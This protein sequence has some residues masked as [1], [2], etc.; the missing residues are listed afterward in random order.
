MKNNNYLNDLNYGD[1]LAE[2]F[3]GVKD[4]FV[5]VLK[6]NILFAF[7]FAGLVFAFSKFMPQ[8]AMSNPGS[9]K[10]SMI[11]FF[12]LYFWL[13]FLFYTATA[14]TVAS[15]IENKDL[16]TFESLN[17]SALPSINFMISSLL[18]S[19]PISAITLTLYLLKIDIG[20]YK[21][22]IQLVLLVPLSFFIFTLFAA[23]LRDKGP[24]ASMGYSFFLIKGN[25]WKTYLYLL[26]PA[27]LCVGLYALFTVGVWFFI[28]AQIFKFMM[29]MQQNIAMFIVWVV[30]IAIVSI[31][32]NIFITTFMCR[33]LGLLFMH[34]ERKV[35]KS[36]PEEVA[37]LGGEPVVKEQTLSPDLPAEK[38]FESDPDSTE[39]QKFYKSLFNDV[40]VDKSRPA[41][42]M[43]TIVVDL[44]STERRNIDEK[45][46]KESFKKESGY[47]NPEITLESTITASVDKEFEFTVEHT[48]FL[49]DK[50]SEST[51]VQ[52]EPENEP[53]PPAV[54]MQKLKVPAKPPVPPA[55]K[56]EDDT[57]D[58]R[59]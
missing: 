29:M 26:V 8:M 34:L 5:P 21:Y 25:W 58:P 40:K 41:N 47:H 33:A 50:P 13:I 31:A 19:V 12:I 32:L 51:S 43:P 27:L 52:K 11:A 54:P 30:V 20:N 44:D 35:L 53:L 46:L 2:C 57:N 42:E 56:K 55:Q 10:A 37:D 18:M 14:N 49:P 38:V 9:I 3:A 16:G 59:M 22:L 28:F 17:A 1:F 36:L 15:Q 23:T 7:L 24:F 45:L 6:L 48:E 39:S 4:S